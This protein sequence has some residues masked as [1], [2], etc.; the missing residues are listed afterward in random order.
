MHEGAP[1]VGYLR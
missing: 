1:T